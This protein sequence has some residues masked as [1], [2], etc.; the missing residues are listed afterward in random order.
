MKKIVL[1][2]VVIAVLAAGAIWFANRPDQ[3]TQ[4]ATVEAAPIA[5]VT[6]SADRVVVDGRVVP[7]QSA[8]LSLPTSGV[9]AE[10][11]AAEGQQ[12]EAGQPL[13]RLHAAQQ[14]AA[15]AQAQA[16]LT[17]A[18]ARLAELKAGA[19][20]QEIDAANAVLAQAQARL[21]RVQN[22]ALPA[23]NAAARAALAEAQAA[24][25]GVLSGASDQQRIA[26]QA[27]LA[28]AEAVQRQ[29]QAAYD[30]V[31]GQADIGARPESAQLEQATNA[32]NAARARLE[33]LN[34]G[35]NASDVAVARAR[36][37]RAQAQLD[38]LNAANPAAVDEAEAA[39]RQAQA[40][41]A[42]LETGVRPETVAVAEADVAAAQAA[43]AQAEAA[44]ADT[45]LR[46]PFAGVVAA[47]N[48]NLGEQVAPGARIV[49]LA[50]LSR[51][52]IETED[53][54]EF[55]VVGVKPGDTVT[56]TFDAL[57]DLSKQGVIER[58]RPIGQDNRGDI[59]YTLVI[60]PTEQDERLLWNMTAVVTIEK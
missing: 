60:D 1:A 42:L 12:V 44:L 53:L 8:E 59:V 57:P 51:W 55:G 32:V 14:Q 47:L 26:A 27:E 54:T 16:Q 33:D 35:A 17:R 29:A 39:V 52:Q 2:V 11:L 28:N 37:A 49:S 20:A 38:L 50:D 46:A 23:E 58:I 48:V 22:G 6:I 41:L 36:V 25:Q 10:I 34:R 18:E 24:L 15:V 40:Q 45:V 4:A 43:L 5:D 9:V 19:Q 7:A 30:R 21:D 56:L 13:L 31:A 3:T